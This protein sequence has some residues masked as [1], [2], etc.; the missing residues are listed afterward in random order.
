M[1]GLLE[2]GLNRIDGVNF[3]TSRQE[4]IKSE[5][6]RL[7]VLNAKEKALELVQPLEQEIGQAIQI[8]EVEEGRFIP[9]MQSMEMKSDRSGGA[10]TIAPGELEITVKVNVTFFL[11]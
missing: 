7:A 11:L 3:Q 4:E 2:S 1:T 8:S 5:A 6:R 10:Q 9:V